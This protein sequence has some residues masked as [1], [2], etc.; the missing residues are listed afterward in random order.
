MTVFVCENPSMATY[1]PSDNL[2]AKYAAHRAAVA[3]EEAAL[4]ELHQA[5]ADE[6]ALPS[7]PADVARAVEYHPGSVARIARAHGVE[8]DPTRRPPAR[9][10]PPASD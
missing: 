8:G 4:K 6:V 7:K 10:T 5:I 2:R 9:T 1:V 3:A